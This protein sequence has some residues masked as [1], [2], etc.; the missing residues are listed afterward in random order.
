MVRKFLKTSLVLM[1]LSIGCKKVDS[2]DTDDFSI[3]QVEHSVV[4]G[5]S[6]GDFSLKITTHILNDTLDVDD[7]KRDKYSSPIIMNQELSFFKDEKLIKIYQLPIKQINVKTLTNASLDIL[8]TPVYE[9]CATKSAAKDF[10]VISG[11]E[12]DVCHGIDCLEF[13]GIYSM[14]GDIVYEGY[15]NENKKVSLEDILNDNQADLNKTKNCKNVD[16]QIH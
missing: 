10:Y 9:I 2:N 6:N 4:T 8:H 12:Y 13:I 14:Q 3:K 5:L 11:A 1:L 16:L 15:F 7:Y